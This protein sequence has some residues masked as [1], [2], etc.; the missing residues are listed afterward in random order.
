MQNYKIQEESDV[1]SE[2]F[3][4]DSASRQNLNVDIR[5]LHSQ[6]KGLQKKDKRQSKKGAVSAPISMRSA[7]SKDFSKTRSQDI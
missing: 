4:S 6:Q 5:S 2:Y 7:N 3:S 1:V